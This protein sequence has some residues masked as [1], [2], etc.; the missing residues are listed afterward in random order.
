MRHSAIA[1]APEGAYEHPIR[2]L[3]FA[4]LAVTFVCTAGVSVGGSAMRPPMLIGHT[5]LDETPSS[6]VVC[7]RMYAPRLAGHPAFLN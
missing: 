6:C 2:P 5:H 4:A 1:F 7:V 3:H